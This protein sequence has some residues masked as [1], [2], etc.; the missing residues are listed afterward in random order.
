MTSRLRSSRSRAS[1]SPSRAA[2]SSTTS[3]SRSARGSSPGS[4]A[5][6]AS[7]RQ[8]SCASSSGC[9]DRIRGQVRVLGNPMSGRGRS[10]GYVPQKVVLDPDVPD[11]GP[12]P[13]GTRPRRPALRLRAAHQGATGTGRQDAPRRRRRALRR[14]PRRDPLGRRAATGPDRPRAHQR[15]E[16]PPSRRATGQSRPEERPGD[17]G[18]AP[19][20]GHRQR[21]GDPPVSARDERPAAGD[22]PD[23]LCDARV[24]RRAA[25]PKRSCDPTSSASSTGITSTCSNSTAGCWSWP[26]PAP[27]RTTSPI[28]LP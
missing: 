23:R 22:G 25:P 9:S 7:A 11:P 18:P 16:A 4:S 15:A 8:R 14:C 28:T 20:G 21:S 17:R 19:P 5:P 3:R 2:R 27:K 12:R 1:A 24:G 26:S 10:L 13:G 6:T